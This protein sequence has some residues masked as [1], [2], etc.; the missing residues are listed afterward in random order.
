M[1]KH[2]FTFRARALRA[3]LMTVLMVMAGAVVAV[4]SAYATDSGGV[5]NPV[6]GCT[7]A[8]TVSTADIHDSNGFVIGRID[9]R[10]SYACAGNWGRTTTYV[11][12]VSHIESRVARTTCFSCPGGAFSEDYNVNQNWSFYIQVG[13]SSPA[14]AK[15]RIFY[16]GYYHEATTCSP[17]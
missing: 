14:C 4:P 9:L 13:A 11:G 3:G 1:S 5:A 15:G 2:W 16:H 12:S 17:N 7:N 8:Y 10:W 6:P